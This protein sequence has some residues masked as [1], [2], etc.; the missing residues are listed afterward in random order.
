[1]MGLLS[2]ILGWGPEDETDHNTLESLTQGRPAQPDDEDA[3]YWRRLVE[4][5]A[6]QAS[7]TH[8]W[9]GRWIPIDEWREMR[10]GRMG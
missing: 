7:I 3:A 5:D 8:V 2:W 6:Q 9:A 10:N 1:M 4:H